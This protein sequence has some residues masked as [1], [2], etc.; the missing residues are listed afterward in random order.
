MPP[1]SWPT[2]STFCD[3]RSASS[4]V[5]RTA[6][7]GAA[8]RRARASRSA[9]SGLEIGVDSRRAAWVKAWLIADGSSGHSAAAVVSEASAV[10]ALR[11]ASFALIRDWPQRPGSRTGASRRRPGLNTAN[12]PDIQSEGFTSRRLS[13]NAPNARGDRE[14]GRRDQAVPKRRGRRRVSGAPGQAHA[15]RA[16]LSVERADAGSRTSTFFQERDARHARGRP[17]PVR[18]ARSVGRSATGMRPGPHSG[19]PCGAP[20]ASAS[21]PPRLLATDVGPLD[22]RRNLPADVRRTQ[23]WARRHI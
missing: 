16:R 4:A 21:A 9:I 11:T 14:V 8:G 22:A 2:A 3:W 19:L 18:D 20:A 13:R 17:R 23:A 15:L 1:V 5:S 10:T 7:L 6:I 12:A